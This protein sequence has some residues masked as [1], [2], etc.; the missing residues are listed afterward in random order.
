HH[1]EQNGIRVMDLDQIQS[2]LT[3]TGHQHIVI[4]KLEIAGN[5]TKQLRIIISRDNRCFFCGHTS[6]SFC[7]H[8][9]N[10]RLVAR[11]SQQD[12]KQIWTRYGYVSLHALY[13]KMEQ[14]TK[15]ARKCHSSHKQITKAGQISVSLLVIKGPFQH[16]HL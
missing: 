10:E 9:A 3:I 13:Y 12:S 8:C 4:L 11:L 15:K 6:H 16:S 5:Q 2:L 7:S 1:V 14:A